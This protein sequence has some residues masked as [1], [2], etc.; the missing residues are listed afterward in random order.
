MAMI[1]L[2]TALG[3]EAGGTARLHETFRFGYDPA[4]NLS[5]RT[6]NALAQTFSVDSLDQLSSV[7]RSGTLTVAGTT[8]SAAGVVA[9]PGRSAAGARRQ[10]TRTTEVLTRTD[11]E[12]DR[13]RRS[14]Y[15][16]VL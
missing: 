2:A 10:I 8:T 12:L 13:T 16:G 1:Q 9:V 5:A 6:N 3:K 4:G 15:A 11:G 7:S 14:G